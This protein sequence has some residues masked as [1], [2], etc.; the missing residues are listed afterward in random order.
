M[1]LFPAFIGL[2]G[3]IGAGAAYT[4]VRKLSIIG[5]KGPCIVAF[6]SGF[7]CLVTLPFLLFDYHPMTLRQLLMLILAGSMA[8]GG[9][10][11]VTAAYSHAPARELSV[12]DYS[13]ILFSALIGFL[14]LGEIPDLFSWIGYVLIIGMA[15]LMFLYNKKQ[16]A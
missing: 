12:Y 15:V 9:Q 3:G 6:F 5:E 16:S 13:Q 8:A 7:S 2:L 10:F 14:V 1:R 11:S 4:C